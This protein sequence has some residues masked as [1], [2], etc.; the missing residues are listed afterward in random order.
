MK[1]LKEYEINQT[2]KIDSMNEGYAV[3]RSTDVKDSNNETNLT[4]A[5]QEIEFYH[6]GRSLY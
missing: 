2:A 6:Q 3:Q 4:E 1:K 5:N